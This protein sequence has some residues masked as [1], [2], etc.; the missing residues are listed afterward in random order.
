MFTPDFS[1]VLSILDR[2][3]PSRPTLFEFFM[4]TPLY[5]KL[6]GRKTPGEENL[7]EHYRFILDAYCHAG[8]DYVTVRGSKFCFPRGE[9]H[10]D[11]SCS[12]NV[13]A[14]ISND[15]WGFKTQ[16]MLRPEEMRTYV[17]P[18]HRK[19]VKAIHDAGKPAILHS[20]GQLDL[21]ME[22]IIGD[23][24]YDAKHSYEDSIEPV[25][26][27][28]ER[29]AGR[30]AVLGGIDVD[31]I[32][33]SSPDAVYDRSRAML[34]RTEKKGGYALGSGNSIPEW[35]PQEGYFAMLRAVQETR[36]GSRA[37]S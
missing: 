13:G 31:F 2:K 7:A 19:I 15:D 23:M 29:L 24:K 37:A 1:N 32:C 26:K 17:F 21:V 34:K 12:L 18:W 27:T 6:T 14:L 30:I 36:D 10:Q 16:T 3:A 5:E 25:E 28:Y 11:K 4:N 8:Y 22:E 9:I 35:V 20:C 33:R